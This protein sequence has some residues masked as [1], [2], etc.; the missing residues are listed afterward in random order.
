MTIFK[1]AMAKAGNKTYVVRIY[2]N[3]SHSLLVS[4]TG[5]PSTGGKEGH[6]VTGFWKMQTDWL[7]QQL[8]LS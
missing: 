5:S 8:R 2:P 3:G 6:F 4:D 7:L 1:R